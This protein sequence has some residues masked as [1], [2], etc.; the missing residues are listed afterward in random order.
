MNKIYEK[1]RD[2]DDELCAVF[3]WAELFE[4]VYPCL[5]LMYHVANEGKRSVI[6]GARLKAKG[7]KK[8]V[9]DITLPAARGGYRGLYIELKVGDGKPT[10]EQ[11]R[12][13]SAL[14]CEGYFVALAYFAAEAIRLIESY[15]KGQVRV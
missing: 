14:Q 8:G 13:M 12:Y 5:W 11:K 7:L 1:S 2:E 9:P 15:V 6:T 10:P 4:G 3:K